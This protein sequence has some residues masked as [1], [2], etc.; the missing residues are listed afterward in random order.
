MK[1]FNTAGPQ[2][3]LQA[4]LQ[5]IINGGGI[6][7]R[8]YGLGTKRTDLYIKW[9][10]VE[11]N[12]GISQKAVI[13]CKLL[14]KTLDQTIQEGLLQ[15]VEYADKCSAEEIHLIVFDRTKV[16]PWEEKIFLREMQSNGRKV[17]VWGM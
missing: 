5:S 10:P 7:N 15:S 8:E 1:F 14:H 11:D 6:I 13:E 17:T 12:P 3:L 2:L 4:F 16:K 9:Y